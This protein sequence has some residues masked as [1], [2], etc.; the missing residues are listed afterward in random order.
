MIDIAL[1][2]RKS[3]PRCNSIS[4]IRRIRLGGYRCGNCGWTGT[5]VQLIS[6]GLRQDPPTGPG[7]RNGHVD[8]RYAVGIAAHTRVSPDRLSR[9]RQLKRENPHASARTLA[10]IGHESEY[11]VLKALKNCDP[12]EPDST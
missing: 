12:E 3:C 8:H 11:A 5:A 4:I 9:I 2:T 7:R 6:V 1:V 10:M